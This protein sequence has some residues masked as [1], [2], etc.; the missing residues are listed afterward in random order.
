MLVAFSAAVSHCAF[1]PGA[2]PLETHKKELKEYDTSKG[3]IRFQT[4]RPLPATL[5]RKLVK[6]RIAQR[7]ARR[8]VATARATRRR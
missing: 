7:E 6:T 3:T 2:L 1:Y 8:P 5:V 4:D